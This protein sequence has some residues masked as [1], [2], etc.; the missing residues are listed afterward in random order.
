MNQR[1]D[2]IADILKKPLSEISEDIFSRPDNFQ[3]EPWYDD[4]DLFLHIGT[5]QPKPEYVLDI[6]K[7]LKVMGFTTHTSEINGELF[8]VPGQE[9]IKGGSQ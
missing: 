3:N 8:L 4:F 2:F 9:E 6:Q 5:C 7:A 1:D